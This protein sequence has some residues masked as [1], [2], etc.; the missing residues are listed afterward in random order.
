MNTAMQSG[1]QDH[2]GV[3]AFL[4]LQKNN[5]GE[6]E[7]VLLQLPV[8]VEGGSS[9]DKLEK[10]LKDEITRVTKYN[11]FEITVFL[12]NSDVEV[13]VP[14]FEAAR[15]IQKGMLTRPPCLLPAVFLKYANRRPIRCCSVQMRWT[16]TRII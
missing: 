14:L 9:L 8:L 13:P 2:F 15:Q 1:G 12:P 3:V 10:D 11:I 7:E 16:T 5:T 4:L 6:N